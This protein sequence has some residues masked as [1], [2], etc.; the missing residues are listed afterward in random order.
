MVNITKLWDNAAFNK[1]SKNSKLLYIYLISNV[2]IN[3]VGVII[4]NINAGLERLIM[5]LEELRDSTKELIDNKYIIVKKIDIIYVVVIDHYKT[6]SKTEQNIEKIRRDF[7]LL[8]SDIQDI[9]LNLKINPNTLH[10][11]FKIPSQQEVEE[12]ALSLGYYV[13]GKEFINFYSE[14]AVR[15]GRPKQ[16][17]DSKGK[18]VRDWKGKLRKVWCKDKN[19]IPYHAEAP[20]GFEHFH[21]VVDGEMKTPDKWI[22]NR[23]FSSDFLVNKELNKEYDSR[24]RSS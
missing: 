21:I 18:I 17:V 3:S 9:L 16:W 11:S 1:L 4:L 5:T 13:N 8:P 23:P 2:S 7:D 12:Y 20:K 24:T 10:V 19:K 15:F 6:V 22:N 14:T